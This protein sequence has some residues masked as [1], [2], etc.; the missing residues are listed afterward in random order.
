MP[1][2]ISTLKGVSSGDT[3]LYPLKEFYAHAKLPLPH[4]EAITGDQVPEPYKTL[5]VHANDMTPTLE[6]FHKD[7]IHLE[8]LRTERRGPFY[9]REV[10]L[11]L[12]G[13]DK[14]VEFGANKIHL[15]CFPEDAQALILE[16]YAPLGRIL[17]E[18]NVRH[19]TEAKAFLKVEVDFVMSEA[20]GLQTPTT[21]YGRKALILDPHNRPLSEI[22]EILPPARS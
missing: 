14:P 16:N 6:Q 11:R 3:H 19:H 17:K 22:V 13:N 7:N 4:I 9:F 15:A 2:S 5:L 8:V 20:F 21:L 18:C 12:N 1:D 10:I